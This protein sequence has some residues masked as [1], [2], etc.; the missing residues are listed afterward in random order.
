[1]NNYNRKKEKIIT[2]FPIFI[3]VYLPETGP[4]T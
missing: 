2:N 4:G 1:M 3:A